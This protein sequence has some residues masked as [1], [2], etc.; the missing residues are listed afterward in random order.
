MAFKEIY[1][2]YLQRGFRIT[3]VH[4][5]G[6]FAPLKVLIESLP[7][8]PMVNLAS[9][10]EHVPEIEQRIRVV[11][12]WSQA[13]RHSLPFQCIPKLLM[14]HIVLN[15]IK[16]LNFFPTKGRISDTLSPKI[17][18]SGETLD[19]MKHLSLQVGQYCQVHEEDTPNQKSKC[20]QELRVP[21]CLDPVVISKEDTSLWL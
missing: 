16:M 19:Y 14:I 17:I 7:G 18:M 9:P 21:F 2:Y 11:K 12:E 5:D 10:N 3:T 1:Q 4:A 15:A 13:A 6:K 20:I 8:G